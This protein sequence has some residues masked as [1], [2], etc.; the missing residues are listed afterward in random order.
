MCGIHTRTCY[1]ISPVGSLNALAY[2]YVYEIYFERNRSV[3]A[4]DSWEYIMTLL[5]CEPTLL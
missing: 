2:V 1:E 5:V 3:L 4:F